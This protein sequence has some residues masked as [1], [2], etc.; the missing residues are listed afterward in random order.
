MDRIPGAGLAQEAVN[1]TLDAVGSVS[2]QARR[3][4]VYAGLGVLGAAG[5]VEWP[6][7]A[8]GA[9]VVWLTQQRPAR[10][11]EEPAAP[12]RGQIAP[13]AAPPR[14]EGWRNGTA[15]IDSG[16]PSG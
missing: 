14:A 9:A 7:A 6:V 15:T 4:A 3:V 11:G 16:A 5:L 1:G 10:G 12:A 2:P 13:Q 8:T